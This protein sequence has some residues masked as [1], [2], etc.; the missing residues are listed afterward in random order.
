M[1]MLFGLMK[2]VLLICWKILKIICGPMKDSLVHIG[3]GI[4]E[5]IKERYRKRKE[6]KAAAAAAAKEAEMTS[7][8]IGPD[9]SVRIT[10]KDKFSNLKDDEL[11]SL[12]DKM[13]DNAVEVD[14]NPDLEKILETY[15]ED[16]EIFKQEIM[17][18][19]KRREM[20]RKKD[21]SN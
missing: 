8:P 3:K 19:L 7:A 20:S 11:Q 10:T 18:E 15:G 5:I 12:L 21:Q 1:K 9:E 4:W 2:M 16:Q 13:T 6:E 14:K 17:D